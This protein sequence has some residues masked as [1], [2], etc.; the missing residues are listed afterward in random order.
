MESNNLDNN[1]ISTMSNFLISKDID[2]YDNI[3][4]ID[5]YIDDN[6]NSDYI[7]ES[8]VDKLKNYNIHDLSKIISILT[9]LL[10]KHNTINSNNLEDIYS[11]NEYLNNKKQYEFN[12]IKV[13]SIDYL[14]NCKY[15]KRY[16][17]TEFSDYL[18]FDNTIN[19]YINF[20][21]NYYYD[22]DTVNDYYDK[23]DYYFNSLFSILEIKID[24]LNHTIIKCQ[25]KKEYDILTDKILNLLTNI[26]ILVNNK[27]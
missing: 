19:N 12:L 27:F 24:L 3:D 6:N 4:D 9:S 8:F 18:N 20:L 2:Q 7:I 21:Y 26:N 5:K 16:I 14:N 1:S 25:I 22:K 23:I 11:N 13:K 17:P 10:T 15:I